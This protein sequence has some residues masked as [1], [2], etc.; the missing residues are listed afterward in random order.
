[1]YNIAISPCPNDTFA[2]YAWIHDKLP[3]APKINVTFADIQDL[4][5]LSQNNAYD[6]IK[7]S[8]GNFKNII[9]SYDLLDVGAALGEKTGPL[10]ISKNL[11]NIKEL[12]NSKVVFPGKTTTAYWLYQNLLEKP[13]KELFSIYYDI[14]NMVLNN[15]CDA[16]V[17]IHETRFALN[18]DLHVIADLGLLFYEKY[19]L[20]VPLGAIAI[21]RKHIQEKKLFELSLKKS[22]EYAKNNPEEVIEFMKEHAQDKSSSVIYKHIQMYVNDRT[23]QLDQK[24]RAVVSLFK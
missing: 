20:P 1:M 12:K 19:N 5:L 14:E 2:F 24:A 16:G 7:I 4:N 10:I 6:L 18:P 8:F 15:D 13:A 22:I 9:E 11:T 23:L 21:S 17:I 3:N